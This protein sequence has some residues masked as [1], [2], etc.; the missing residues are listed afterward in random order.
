MRK[1]AFAFAVFCSTLPALALAQS[2]T[3]DTKGLPLSLHQAQVIGFADAKEQVSAPS[4]RNDMPTS[5]MQV[6]VLTPRHRQV[7]NAPDADGYWLVRFEASL[8]R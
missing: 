6:L 8:T 3:Y 4:L 5:P 7:A 2:A 1:S